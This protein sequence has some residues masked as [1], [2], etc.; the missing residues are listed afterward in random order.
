[1]APDT[2]CRVLEATWPPVDKQVTAR[3]VARAV[4]V[5]SWATAH[6]PADRFIVYA[7]RTNVYG[8]LRFDS[9]EPLRHAFVPLG[10][11]RL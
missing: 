6:D 7:H 4:H 8:P 1:M 5:I 9:I 11:T 2:V 10:Q 3:A